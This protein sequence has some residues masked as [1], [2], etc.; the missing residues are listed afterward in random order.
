MLFDKLRKRRLNTV[1]DPSVSKPVEFGGDLLFSKDELGGEL[2]LKT[3]DTFSI[4][5]RNADI[6]RLTAVIA[7]AFGSIDKAES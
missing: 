6:Q 2:S 5:K 1:L 4:S 3:G 7:Q